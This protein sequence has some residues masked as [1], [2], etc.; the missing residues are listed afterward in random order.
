MKPFEDERTRRYKQ[1]VK[2]PQVFKRNDAPGQRMMEHTEDDGLQKRWQGVCKP[3]NTS[4]D[5]A[6][7]HSQEPRSTPPFLCIPRLARSPP[8]ECRHEQRRKRKAGCQ[9]KKD[10]EQ[11]TAHQTR[12]IR[13]GE[14]ER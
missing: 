13:C 10:P 4:I 5:T 14:L 9:R 7:D 12:K 8:Q 6:T 2:P 11:S 1:K 3:E